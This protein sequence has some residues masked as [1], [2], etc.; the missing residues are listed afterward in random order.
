MPPDG[1]LAVLVHT[2]RLHRIVRMAW[3]DSVD[4]DDYDEVGAD[5]GRLPIERPTAIAA[6]TSSPRPSAGFL[7]R[8]HESS[9]ASKN[10]WWMMMM[11]MRV[12]DPVSVE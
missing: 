7:R 9:A 5:G 6:P 2:H 1:W 8:V 3:H 12:M 10:G 4:G 11:M